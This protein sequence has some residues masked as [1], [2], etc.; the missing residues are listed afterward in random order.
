M[1]F[2]DIKPKKSELLRARIF[3]RAIDLFSEKGYDNV[4]ISDI[5]AAA[6]V[7]TGAF[8]YHFASKD[9]IFLEYA[10]V[11]DKLMDSMAAEIKCDSQSER[12]KQLVLATVSM[13]ARV[14]KDLCNSCLVAFIKYL[15]NSYSDLSRSVYAHF[16]H[17]IELGKG[18]GEFR[19]DVDTYLVTS[20]LRYMLCGLILHWVSSKEQLDLRAETEK[21]V[22]R[23][24]AGLQ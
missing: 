7:S 17:T 23:I 11:S 20:D 16:M 21:I 19:P 2:M 3:N 24:I 1:D 12:L 5:C 18:S 15:D 13:F 4:K 9:A 10:R 6:D 8:Y 14:G 22:E